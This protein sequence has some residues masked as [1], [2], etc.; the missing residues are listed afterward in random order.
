MLWGGCGVMGER[1][2][3]NVRRITNI[4]CLA[5]AVIT[6]ALFTLRLTAFNRIA[7]EPEQEEPQSDSVLVDGASLLNYRIRDKIE[8]TGAGQK[9]NITIEN[10]PGNDYYMRL[11]IIYDISGKSVYLSPFLAPGESVTSAYLQGDQLVM[12]EYK[13]TAVITAY[14][15]ATREEM[16]NHKQPVTITIARQD[17]SA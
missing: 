9:G 13:C 12:G 3:P 5:I 10:D 7:R 11:E 2:Y 6:M 15:P 14:D 16:Q 8:F 17:A 4:F 1:L